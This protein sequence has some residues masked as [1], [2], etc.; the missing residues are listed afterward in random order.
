MASSFEMHASE[1]RRAGD[2]TIE[3]KSSS[4]EAVLQHGFRSSATLKVL[5]RVPESSRPIKKRS[6][7]RTPDGIPESYLLFL[8]VVLIAAML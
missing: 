3:R 6:P 5:K 2:L 8:L 1:Q 7:V 4:R